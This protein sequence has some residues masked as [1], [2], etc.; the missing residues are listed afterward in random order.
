M[1]S[2]VFPKDGQGP[3]T[4]TRTWS[5]PYWYLKHPAAW[6]FERELRDILGGGCF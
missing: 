3:K 1:K 6:L 5:S 4:L 2:W